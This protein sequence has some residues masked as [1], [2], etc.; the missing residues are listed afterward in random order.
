MICEK[1]MHF[2]GTYMYPTSAHLK[3]SETNWSASKAALLS[4]EISRDY[5][6][7]Q[8]RLFI[9]VCSDKCGFSEW[10]DVLNMEQSFVSYFIFPFCKMI[11]FYNWRVLHIYIC[12]MPLNHYMEEVV[13]LQNIINTLFYLFFHK[14]SY[15]N[16]KRQLEGNKHWW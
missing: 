1:Y 4:H 8:L 2:L 5:I 7:K 10:S 14:Y 12:K 9:S 13:Q 15:I 3:Y 11:P 16:Y 6:N